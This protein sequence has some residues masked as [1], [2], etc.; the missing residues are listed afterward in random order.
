MHAYKACCLYALQLYDEAKRE[1]LKAPEDFGL[2]NRLIFH[3]AHKKNDEKNLMQYHNR[4]GETVE[5]NLTLAA[6]HYLRGHYE[7]ASE[8][9]KKLLLEN[10]EFIA[11]NV[12]V[13]LCYYK[14]DFFDVS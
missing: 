13:A 12:Y 8:I 2:T 11:I 4:I 10:R 9:Y 7:E 3:L 6:V 1:C 14:M 5:D